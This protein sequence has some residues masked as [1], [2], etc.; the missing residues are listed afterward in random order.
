[1][2]CRV[3]YFGQSTTEKRAQA[4]ESWKVGAMVQ[5]AMGALRPREADGGWS[6]SQCEETGGDRRAKIVTNMPEVPI[7]HIPR[8]LSSGRCWEF[9]SSSWLT[10]VLLS[11]WGLVQQC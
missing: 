5:V 2:R 6:L 8:P 10:A 9:L 11:S 3:D 4:P 1:M 7:P